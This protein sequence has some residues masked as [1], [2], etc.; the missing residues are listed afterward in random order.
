MTY[1]PLRAPSPLP[2]HP[3]LVH[4]S[5]LEWRLTWINLRSLMA[6]NMKIFYFLLS[7]IESNI[8]LNHFFG[9]IQTLN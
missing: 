6:K 9:K 1:P 2:P 8:G 7:N 3:P 4:L 5:S